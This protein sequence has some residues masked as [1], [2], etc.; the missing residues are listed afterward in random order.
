MIF[1]AVYLTHGRG[2]DSPSD[3]LD[4]GSQSGRYASA[5]NR[6]ATA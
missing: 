3:A 1:G 6:I 5:S 2:F 4:E